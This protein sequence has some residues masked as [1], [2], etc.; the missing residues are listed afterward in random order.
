MVYDIE[1]VVENIDF[2]MAMEDMSLTNK[3]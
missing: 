1:N 3:V 2:S